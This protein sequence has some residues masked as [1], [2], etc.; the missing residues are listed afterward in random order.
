MQIW[1]QT[2]SREIKIMGRKDKSAVTFAKA[3]A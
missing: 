3:I 2:T 1:A